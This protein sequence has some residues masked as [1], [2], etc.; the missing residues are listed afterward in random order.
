[1]PLRVGTAW[2]VLIAR[3]LRASRLGDE[4]D[5]LDPAIIREA[6]DRVRAADAASVNAPTA[7]WAL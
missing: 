7:E 3:R 2:H 6:A 1:M 4:D 5:P